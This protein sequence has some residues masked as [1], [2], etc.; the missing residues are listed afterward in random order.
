MRDYLIT[1]RISSLLSK[2]FLGR[3]FSRS[4]LMPPGRAVLI[5][6]SF[7]VQSAAS[8]IGMYDKFLKDYD[9]IVHNSKL[10][11]KITEDYQFFISRIQKLIHGSLIFDKDGAKM[12][13]NNGLLIP[14]STA[15][16]S[17]RELSPLLFFIQN[18][19]VQD[20]CVC[21]EEPEAHAH[22]EMQR[23]IA[24]LLVSCIQRGTYMQVTTHS[25]Y[26]LNRLNQLIR[27]YK[28]HNDKASYFSQIQA[29]YNISPRVLLNPGIIKAYYFSLRTDNSV[30]VISQNVE[31]GIPFS[32]FSNVI[33]TQ[34]TTDEYINAGLET[35][36][37]AK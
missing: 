4:L 32:S 33:K 3:S 29:E 10:D 16:S 18:L 20:Y 31:N 13:L 7:T 27:L 22:P 12:K 21:L 28:L 25:D 34:Y 11:K 9:F 1:K 36:D 24:D 26:L 5:D 15:A 19:R 17:I 23:D 35:E 30:E 6:S 14:M 8:S 2:K 37:D